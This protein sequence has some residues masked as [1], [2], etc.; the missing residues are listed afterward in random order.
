MSRPQTARWL[1]AALVLAI[2]PTSAGVAQAPIVGTW[3]GTSTCADKVAFPAC[4]DEVVVYVVRA[5]DPASDSVTVRAD[6]V[7]GDTL[8]FMGEIVFGEGRAGTWQADLRT[9]RYHDRWSLVV[10]GD[11]MTGTLV[12]LP[13]GRVVRNVSLR[14]VPQ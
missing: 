8:E 6:K 13:S 5:M 14:R 11:G 10:A 12:D 3:R 2:V 1:P 9:A 4:H 7:V